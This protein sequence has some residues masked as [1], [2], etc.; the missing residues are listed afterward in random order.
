MACEVKYFGRKLLL[1][2]KLRVYF[3]FTNKM[4]ICCYR[5]QMLEGL[6]H[7]REFIDYV[8]IAMLTFISVNVH[9]LDQLPH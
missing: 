3:S 7:F 2:C 5:L 6:S 9:I 8:Y 4:L 1:G